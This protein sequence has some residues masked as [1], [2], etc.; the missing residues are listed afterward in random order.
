MKNIFSTIF[1]LVSL[2]IFA[3]KWQEVTEDKF[4]N[5]Y[6]IKSSYVSKGGEYGTEKNIIK[7]W[8]KQTVTQIHLKNGKV[9]KN[10]YI[11]QLTEFDC[12]KSSTKLYSR[13]VYSA[14]GNIIMSDN[15]NSFENDWYVV[16]PDTVGEIILNKI[17]ELYN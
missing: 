16:V 13:I 5:K 14:K 15:Y 8:T 10:A 2:S 12:K 3:Q 7:I 11:V 1:L 6:Y 17:C 9:Y 4:G